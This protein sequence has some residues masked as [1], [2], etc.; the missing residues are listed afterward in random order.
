M[1]EAT[2]DACNYWKPA[3]RIIE[4]MSVM[5][6]CYEVTKATELKHKPFGRMARHL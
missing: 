1:Y 3:T 2:K 5:N 6:P 4:R